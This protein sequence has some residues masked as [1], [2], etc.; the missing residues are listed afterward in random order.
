MR[1]A[2]KT[3]ASKGFQ[4]LAIK[5]YSLTLK[6]IKNVENHKRRNTK[7]KCHN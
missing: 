6:N 2:L 4:N 5:M 1:V 7:T 3:S